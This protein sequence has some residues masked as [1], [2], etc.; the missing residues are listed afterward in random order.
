MHASIQPG[1][2][3][4]ENDL[5]FCREGGQPIE[6]RYVSER[7]DSLSKEAKLTRIRFHDLRHTHA[8]LALQ[9]GVHPKVVQERLGHST[10]RSPCRRTPTFCL[11]CRR[12]PRLSS[13]L[14]CSAMA[15]AVRR[16][17]ASERW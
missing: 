16:T 12:R 6:P 5:I 7:F 14:L 9:A 1:D 3:Y 17:A 13:H 4:E 15:N 10:F 8:T 2:A 11:G